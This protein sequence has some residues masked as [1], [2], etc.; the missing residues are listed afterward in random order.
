MNWRLLRL[1]V[2]KPEQSAEAT[3]E[4]RS[5]RGGKRTSDAS[6]GPRDVVEPE[7]YNAFGITEPHSKMLVHDLSVGGSGAD[8]R[9]RSE[10]F[11]KLIEAI[12]RLRRRQHV[13]IIG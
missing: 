7:H 11:N 10:L 13:A 1:T 4:S 6:G 2:D 9:L 12:E 8:P 3:S 5:T